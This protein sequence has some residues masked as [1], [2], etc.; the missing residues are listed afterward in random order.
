MVRLLSLVLLFTLS[1]Q[2]HILDEAE[3]QSSV[4]PPAP[5]G[6]DPDAPSDRSEPLVPNPLKVVLTRWQRD[7]IRA[8]NVKRAAAGK[9]PV[10]PANSLMN[11]AQELAS[12]MR[13]KNNF[14]HRNNPNGPTSNKTL[15]GNGFKAENIAAGN[16]SVQAT[17]DQLY[18]SAGHRANMLSDS[19]TYIGVGYAMRT[20]KESQYPYYWA[21]NYSSAP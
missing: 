12:A 7:Y 1:A 20:G 14:S 5:Q 2:A 6:A 17:V 13:S 16:G 3:T 8:V 19:Y 9:K 11:G 10:A 18:N 15:P 21:E 4:R